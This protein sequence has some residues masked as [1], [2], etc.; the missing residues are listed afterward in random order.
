MRYAV[1]GLMFATGLLLGFGMVQADGPQLFGQRPAASTAPVPAG[2]VRT[3]Q[4]A[5][6]VAL[7]SDGNGGPQ[8][9]LVLDARSRALAVYHVDRSSG[10]VV[11]K[12]ARNLQADLML[13]EF[14]SGEPSPQE[15]RS[16]LP[17]R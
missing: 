1:L 10:Q 16:L 7:L 9:L 6:C 17:P 5:D 2:N 13:D 11:L 14:N 3:A 15:I 4:A 8:Q 12:S